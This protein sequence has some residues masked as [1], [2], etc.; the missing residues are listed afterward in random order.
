MSDLNLKLTQTQFKFILELSQSIPAVFAGE[1]EDETVID[2]LPLETSEPAREVMQQTNDSLKTDAVVHLRP[3]LGIE[4]NTWTQ[5]DMVFNVGSIGL[6]LFVADPDHPIEDLEAASLSRASLNKTHFKL[7]MISNGSIESELLIESF[8]IEDSRK[9]ESNKFRKFMSSTNKEGSQFMASFTLSG[10]AERNLMALLTI[11]SPRIIFALDYIFA[12]RDFVMSGLEIEEINLTDELEESEESEDDSGETDMRPKMPMSRL[13]QGTGKSGVLMKKEKLKTPQQ[14][15]MTISFR[16][17][18]VDSQVI[19]IANPATSNSEAIVLG[20]KQILLSQQNALTLQVEEVGMFL[21]RMDKFETSR[22]RILDDFTLNF[23][24]DNRSLGAFQSI[25]SIRVEVEP[26]VLRV[27]LRDILL[28]TQIFNKAS[29]MS[30]PNKQSHDPSVSEP[31]KIKQLKGSGKS[32]KRR[33]ASGRGVSTMA[34][35][36]GKSFTTSKS[37]TSQRVGPTCAGSSIVK[38]EE[39]T[40]EFNGMRVVLIGDQHELPLLDLSVKHFTAR[41]RDWSG[42]MDAD[43]N[44][45]TF[46][47]IY[48]FSKSAWEPLAEPW[49]LSFHMSRTLH[50]ERLSIDLISRKTL[51]ITVTSQTIAL[52]SKAAQFMQQDEDMLTKPRGVDSPYRIRN[53][54]GFALNVWAASDSNEGQSMAIKLKDGEQAPWRFE[55]WEK[56]R[57]VE[58]Q[59]H[60]PLRALTN[61]MKNLSPEGSSGIVGVKIEESG[62][63]SVTEIP[64]NREGETLYTLRP[65]KNGILHRLLCEVHLGADNI[66]Y[67]TFRSPLVVE[68]NTQIPVELGVLDA[69]GQHI[70]RVYKVLPG[71]SQPAPIEAAYHQSLVLRPDGKQFSFLVPNTRSSQKNRGFWVYLVA[72]SFRMEE[73]FEKTN[74]MH[75]LR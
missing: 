8:N 31:T 45:E 55:E 44:I 60:I 29:E 47:N 10:G 50:P 16:V 51:E 4:L 58:N 18:I 30:A 57:E 34:K 6:E 67:I 61:F 75:Y 9:Q 63:E 70:I 46:V 72:R 49:Q 3:E 32:L 20:T 64:V 40:A 12:V 71:E 69:E 15:G 37:T 24:M 52:A 66:K 26:L 2:E 21:C 38:R 17:N 19:L 43:T 48:N 7:R 23:S 62:F 54:T 35:N 36:G 41:I 73:P 25:Q 22:L 1:P 74:T 11:D 59:A 14:Q 39:L 56:M 27:S 53:Q 42:D 28:A 5:L 68:N 33:T 65:A 13:T